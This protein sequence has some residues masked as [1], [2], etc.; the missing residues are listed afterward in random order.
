MTD[1]TLL[2]GAA[3]AAQ[4][5]PAASLPVRCFRRRTNRGTTLTPAVS[6]V[7]TNYSEKLCQA[8]AAKLCNLSPFQF[9][10]NFKKEHGLTFRNFVVRMRI[11]RAAELMAR[12]K[13][14]V[15][16]AAFMV[17]F[18]D[19]S[20]FARMFRK[21]LGVTPSSYRLANERGQMPSFPSH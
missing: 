16:Y 15:T 17:G 5:V 12:S 13:V 6:Y 10:R 19:L 3:A 14:S 4:V 18:N 20:Y 11:E 2:C 1:Q 9:S 21:Q 8:T 7:A